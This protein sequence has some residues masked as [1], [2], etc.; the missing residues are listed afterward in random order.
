MND[1]LRDLPS[2]PLR[3]SAPAKHT[4]AYRD[5][6]KA[7]RHCVEID[8]FR[9]PFCEARVN[10]SIICLARSCVCLVLSSCVPS[11][12]HLVVRSRELKFW[13]KDETDQGPSNT[14]HH[15]DERALLPQQHPTYSIPDTT[16]HTIDQTIPNNVVGQHRYRFH[17]TRR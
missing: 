7:R 13:D 8:G 1:W 17:I 2:Q 3:L 4:A 6:Q 9:L 5:R 15:H 16:I 10:G 12:A 14:L 11:L